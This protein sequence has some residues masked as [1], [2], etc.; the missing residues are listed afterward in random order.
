MLTVRRAKK[1]AS[2]SIE[3]WKSH[4][5]NSIQIHYSLAVVFSSPLAQYDQVEFTAFRKDRVA[6]C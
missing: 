3:D 6:R 2:E 1:P 5:V 4:D